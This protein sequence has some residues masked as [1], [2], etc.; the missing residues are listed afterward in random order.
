M[1]GELGPGAA[2]ATEAL[3]GLLADPDEKTQ[4]EA[5][6]AL[7]EI[8]PDAEAA[9]PALSKALESEGPVRFAAAYALGRIGKKAIKAK[10]GLLAKLKGDESMG[11]VSAWAL[12]HIHPECPA[13]QE[14]AL[15]V[16][17]AGLDDASAEFRREAA[18][19]IC[20]FGEAAKG[21]VEKLKKALNDSDEDVREAAAAALKAIDK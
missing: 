12:A 19:G 2:P 16:L 1:L 5:A 21:A 11:L 8:G 4:S 20:C 9:V 3:A 13:C 6:F 15:P 10:P 14:K 7:A 17:I 18:S